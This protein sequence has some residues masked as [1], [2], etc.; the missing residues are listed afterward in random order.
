MN[1][2]IFVRPGNPDSVPKSIRDRTTHRAEHKAVN[3][4]FPELISY[5][6]RQGYRMTEERIPF[7]NGEPRFG[8]PLIDGL[9]FGTMS[10][11]I[12]D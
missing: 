7:P 1:D 6:E 8:E 12:S 4:R 5:Y 9:M 11:P 10:R 3:E 2:M